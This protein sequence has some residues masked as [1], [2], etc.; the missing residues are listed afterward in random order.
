MNVVVVSHALLVPANRDRWRVLAQT[1]NVHVCLI[2]PKNWVSRWLGVK[3]V[4]QGESEI[5]EMFEVC[6]LQV[7]NPGNMMRYTYISLDMELKRI[8]PDIIQIHQEPTSFACIQTLLYRR[9]W[10]PG[11][12]TLIF[13]WNNI[14]T[15][16]RNP[17]IR[18][19]K[20]FTLAK[21][22]AF[23]AGNSE[24][25]SILLDEGFKKP[26]FVQTEIGVNEKIWQPIQT[27]DKEALSKRFTIGFVGRLEPSKGVWDLIQSV[28][29]LD[30]DWELLLVG[31]GPLAEEIT[32]W[33]QSEE[34]KNRVRILSGL[35]RKDLPPVYQ[36]MDVLVLPSRTTP[37]WKE[38]FGLVLAEAMLSGVPVIGSDSGAIGEVI[39]DAGLIF[40]EG[41]VEALVRC[42]SEVMR[43][44]ELRD[45]MAS[46][47]YSRAL[48]LYSTQ[49]LAENTYAIYNE[50][51]MN[52][53]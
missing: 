11:A 46:R 15:R 18:L 43:K 2:V 39:G 52:H 9:L 17:I 28:K 37:T 47:G 31:N 21:T 4:M 3:Q 6:P 50:L 25:K 8:K 29:R 49:A 27:D 26:I 12:K 14:S 40:P 45:E 48:R 44:K 51:L 19:L 23:I 22:D 10:A 5:G 1:H 33:I 38:Q 41:N 32:R 7:L 13:T 35:E 20:K 34:C 30:E 24:A 42:L 16:A 53:E 36:S